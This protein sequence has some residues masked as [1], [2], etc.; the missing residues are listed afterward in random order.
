MPKT[1][2]HL[3]EEDRDTLA[4][5]FNA[6]HILISIAHFLGCSVSTLS[7]EIRR[8]M[9]P[10]GYRPHA[11]DRAAKR[12]FSESH[13]RPRINHPGLKKHI[14]TKMRIGWSPETIAGRLKHERNR[15]TD[16]VTKLPVVSHETIY[17]WV[18][19]DARHL[20]PSLVR[21]HRRRRVVSEL[22]V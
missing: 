17:Q 6:G 8:N 11:A 12:R 3:N 9:T 2:R 21:S 18:Y 5:G 16:P 22:W 13:Q 10:T 4:I 7:R 20:I 14:E 15:S 1:F 19:S